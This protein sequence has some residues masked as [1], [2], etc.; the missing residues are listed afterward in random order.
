[1]VEF[2]LQNKT[3]EPITYRRNDYFFEH[4]NKLNPN[5]LLIDWLFNSTSTQKGQ[6]VIT[7]GEETGSIWTNHWCNIN[8]IMHHKYK[9]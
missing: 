1:M 6:F 4:A 8:Y 3:W 7:A 9:L 5:A 2:T